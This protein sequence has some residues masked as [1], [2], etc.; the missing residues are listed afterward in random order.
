MAKEA[1]QLHHIGASSGGETLVE[2][3]NR[4]IGE[5][6]RAMLANEN[7]RAKGAVTITIHLEPAGEGG[8]HLMTSWDVTPKMPKEA[9]KAEVLPVQTIDGVK[10]LVADP[11]PGFTAPAPR[12]GDPSLPGVLD[13]KAPKPAVAPPATAEG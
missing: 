10:Y 2:K 6:T 1:V 8:H 9:K 4:L 11:V 12:E 13:F 3:A 5:V 7:P